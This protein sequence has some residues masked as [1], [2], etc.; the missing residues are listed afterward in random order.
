MIKVNTVTDAAFVVYAATKDA[1]DESRQMFESLI[2][3][4][5]GRKL[6]AAE[7][8]QAWYNYCGFLIL[9]R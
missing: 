5:L 6:N 8:E 3:K 2:E 9:D 1:S 4:I 7:L